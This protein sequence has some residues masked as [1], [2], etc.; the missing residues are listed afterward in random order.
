MINPD[1]VFYGHLRK[2]RHLQNLNRF[3]KSPT[4][5]KQPTC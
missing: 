5:G 2:D 1:G 4:Q 3:Y